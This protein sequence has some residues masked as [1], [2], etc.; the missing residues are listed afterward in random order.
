MVARGTPTGSLL[1]LDRPTPPP[2]PCVYV[3]VLTALAVL[4]LQSPQ[5][6]VE[7]EIRIAK[8]E[9]HLLEDF[10]GDVGHGGL[11]WYV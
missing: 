4:F 7:W 3:I 9:F 2:P 1:D 11:C 5:K 8:V 6:L 10:G